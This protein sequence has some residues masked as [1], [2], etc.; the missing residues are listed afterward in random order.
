MPGWSPKVLKS[1]LNA[2]Q[3]RA[4]ALLASGRSCKKTAEIVGVVQETISLWKRV[5]EFLA[6]IKRIQDE[7]F[8]KEISKIRRMA[9]SYW[10]ESAVT[11]RELSKH[12]E[13]DGDRVQAAGKLLSEA[14]KILTFSAGSKEQESGTPESYAEAVFEVREKM[15]ATIGSP[16]RSEDA[17][18]VDAAPISPG[19]AP[20]LEQQGE[21]PD[22]SGGSEERED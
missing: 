16:P 3:I 14:G 19:A 7:D 11:L 15:R 2:K 6:E 13:K 9:G 10:K 12:A 21:V 4:A 5:P 18:A 8:A 1:V 20:T 17:A 22:C